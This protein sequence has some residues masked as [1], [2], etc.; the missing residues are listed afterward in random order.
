[1]D[2]ATIDRA[3]DF[4]RDFKKAIETSDNEFTLNDDGFERRFIQAKFGDGKLVYWLTTSYSFYDNKLAAVAAQGEV[5]ICEKFFFLP[6]ETFDRAEEVGLK[7]LADESGKT[8]DA[9]VEELFSAWY[10]ELPLNKVRDA[11]PYYVRRAALGVEDA[12]EDLELLQTRVRLTTD[13]FIQTLLGLTSIDKLFT[14]KA[15]GIEMAAISVKSRYA[16]IA[17]HVAAGEGAEP[18]EISL[19]QAVKNTDAKELTV[20]LSA[21]ERSE[22]VKLKKDAFLDDILRE[23][24]ISPFAF[25]TYS[26]G[27]QTIKEL[28]DGHDIP[29]TAIS[30]VTYKRKPVWQKPVETNTSLVEVNKD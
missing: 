18:W 22:S 24:A 19:Y 26:K 13:D 2:K 6:W 29:L 28:F 12:K 10:E 23:K 20:L 16:A 15:Q 9:I 11:D 8:S 1:M 7:I 27:C 21:P 17:A 14:E 4:L 30:M 25:S 3:L 5:Y